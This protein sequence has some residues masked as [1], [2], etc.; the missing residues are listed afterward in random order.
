MTPSQIIRN[1]HAKLNVFLRVLGLRDDGFHEIES[2]ILPLSLQDVVRADAADSLSLRLSGDRS[3]VGV[4]EPLGED[5]LVIRAALLVSDHVRMAPEAQLTLEKWVPVAAGLGGGSAD[6]A[7]AM[8][9]LDELWG[10]GLGRR[11]LMEIGA[12]LGSDIPALLHGGPVLVRGRGEIVDP[13]HA[14]PT[15]W[16]VRPF[17]FGIRVADAYGWWDA[18][19]RT[20]P[21]PGALIAALEKGDLELLGDALY[22]DLQGPIVARHPEIGSAIDR[23]LSAGALGAVVSGSGPT[24]VALARNEEHAKELAADVAGALVVA[25]PPDAVVG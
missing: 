5:N 14:S 1:A 13:V 21:D 16:A 11:K 22:D 17:G 2:V 24:V 4:L 18:S 20:G 15:Y 7:A 9:A 10:L 25:G 3:L 6:A 8:L 23:W 12:A 19:G